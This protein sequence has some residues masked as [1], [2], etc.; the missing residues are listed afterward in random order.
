MLKDL[1]DLKQPFSVVIFASLGATLSNLPKEAEETCQKH[2]KHGCHGVFG[3]P[4]MIACARLMASFRPSLPRFL[5]KQSDQIGH[6]TITV[7]RD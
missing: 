3:A 4:R 1:K 6:V 7:G 2:N 5:E